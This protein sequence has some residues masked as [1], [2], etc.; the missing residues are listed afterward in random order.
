MDKILYSYLWVRKDI[1]LADQL[2]Q[3][4]HAAQNAGSRWGCQPNTH[5]LLFQVDNIDALYKI[6]MECE[7]KNINYYMFNEPDS[8]YDDGPPMRHTAICTEP[9]EGF[10][11]K[12]TLWIP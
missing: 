1:P 7:K 5:M 10:M 9:V 8:A 6:A 4:A 3:T 2:V 12:G 11:F